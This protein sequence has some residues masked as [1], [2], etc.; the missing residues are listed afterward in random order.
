[1]SILPLHHPAQLAQELSVIDHLSEG[2]LDVTVGIGHRA[3]EY[4]AF[5][6]SPRT[7]PSRMEEAI[8][9]LKLAWTEH[10]FSYR[11]R[12]VDV[13]DLDVRPEP[14]QQPHPPLWVAATTAPAAARAGRHGAHLHAASVDPAVYDGYRD[15]LRASGHDPAGFRVSNPWSITTTFEEP[16]AVWERNRDKYFYRW[17]FYRRIREEMGDPDLDYGLEPS[18]DVYRA[19]ELIGSPETVLETLEPF[20]RDLGLTDLVVFGPASGID[21]RDEGYASL[22]CFAE[23][24]LPTVKSW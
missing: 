12:Y 13:R 7:R 15:A 23:H 16:D 2:R 9:V 8:E 4:V 3:A 10:P 6:Y 24:V 14:R 19:N 17:D 11:G 22:R 1:V 18:P 20:C 5:G 21:L